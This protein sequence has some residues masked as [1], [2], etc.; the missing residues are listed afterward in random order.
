MRITAISLVVIISLLNISNIFSQSLKPYIQKEIHAYRLSENET[1]VIDGDG[2]DAVWGEVAPS[3]GFTQ[4]NPNPYADPSQKTIVRIAYDTEAIYVLGVMLD[5]A[6]DSIL[7][8]LSER[9]RLENTD[10]FGF[11]FSPYNDGSNG[12]IFVT[13]PAGIQ[14]DMQVSSGGLDSGWDAV[15]EVETSLNAEGW[16][17]EFKI[18]WSALRFSK[19]PIDEDQ[20]WGVNFDRNIRRYRER[21]FWRSVDP[22]R[23]G[24][25]I[26]ESG[27]LHGLRNISPPTR[28]SINPYISAYAESAEDGGLGTLVN[29]GLDLKAGIGDAFTLD[30]TLIPD[31]GQVVSD[32]L[33]LNLSPYEIRFSDNRP[34]FTEGTEIFNKTG[35]FYSRRVGDEGQLVN[36]TKFS[37]RTSSGLGIGA[38]QAFTVNDTIENGLTSYSVAALDQTLPNNS[39]IHAISTYVAREGDGTDALVQGTKFQLRNKANTYELSGSGAYNQHYSNV[40]GLGED[41]YKWSMGVRKISGMFTFSYN[42]TVES[43]FYDPND[44]GYLRA[45]NEVGDFIILGLKIIEPTKNFIRLG[46][47]ATYHQSRLFEPREKTSNM[48]SLTM[49]ALSQNFQYINIGIDGQPLEGRNYFDSRVDGLYWI[50]PRWFAPRVRIST[51]YSKKL[52]IDIDG[53]YGFVED[54]GNDWNELGANISPR[55]RVSDKL[56]FRYTYD[57]TNKI[58]QKDFAYL[59]EGPLD[60]DK[61]VFG[62]RDYKT[63]TQIF[64]G[65]Y[66]FSR[67][68]SIEARIR[69]NWSTVAYHDFYDLQI[70][71]TLSPSVI[72]FP[73]EDGTTDYDL[74]YNAWSVDLGFKW[75]FSPGSELSVVWKNT[76]NSSGGQLPTSYIDNWE[77]MLEESFVNSLSIKAL[78]Y[79][80]Y[81]SV[82]TKLRRN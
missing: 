33:V 74:N 68:A 73:N 2:D 65:S 14:V 4:H 61:S 17:A 15:W 35:L 45:P 6:P 10:E 41:G 47:N 53:G 48:V 23:D 69:H 13:S 5:T 60:G 25:D 57:F 39:Y 22:A 12:F 80:D 40:A 75:Y 56:S 51:D 64:S 20:I 70:D 24:F 28:L 8:Q 43:E 63:K 38:F 77:Q 44:L 37:G 66:S 58:N 11:W 31:F 62:R 67:K 72:L 7:M 32:N 34:F 3:S 79:L 49:H 81:N 18:P 27:E 9:D 78:F 50:T 71:G 16:V 54:E 19:M 36:A 1:I 26:Y 82:K 55:F 29:G 76:L 42:H 21:S 52:A 46:V 30:M 59:I